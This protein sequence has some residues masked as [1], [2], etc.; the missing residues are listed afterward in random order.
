MK[1]LP[2][3][4]VILLFA[5]TWLFSNNTAH[6]QINRLP[7]I[8]EEE[9]EEQLFPIDIVTS[10]SFEMVLYPT[11]ETFD[12]AATNKVKHT[13]KNALLL[14]S[15]ITTEFVSLEVIE[16]LVQRVEFK[17]NYGLEE[18]IV[19][20]GPDKKN[21]TSHVQASL[22]E[23]KVT[24]Y[25]D[26]QERGFSPPPSQFATDNLI[27]RTFSQPSTKS[28]FIEFITLTRDPFL[29]EVEDIDINLVEG[30][31]EE[32][33][34]DGAIP[35]SNID[36]VLIV[37]SSFILIGIFF[38]FVTHHQKDGYEDIRQKDSFNEKRMLATTTN[39]NNNRVDETNNKDDSND[40]EEDQISLGRM[41]PVEGNIIEAGSLESSIDSQSQIVLSV[42]DE[43]PAISFASSSSS[44]SNSSSSHSSSSSSSDSTY[45]ASPEEN[46]GTSREAS[47]C[48]PKGDSTIDSYS[49][50]TEEHYYDTT[51]FTKTTSELASKLLSLSGTDTYNTRRKNNMVHSSS[52]SAPTILEQTIRQSK[53]ESKMDEKSIKSARS[54]ASSESLELNNKRSTIIPISFRRFQ[55]DQVV[56]NGS[57]MLETT[58]EFHNS[59]LE[60]KIKALEDIEEGSIDDV[61]QI[62]VQRNEAAAALE[63]NE[64][65]TSTWSTS[66]SEWMKSIRVVSSASETQSSV[67]HSSIEPKSS[68][69]RENNS[70]DLSLEDSLATSLVEF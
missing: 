3:Y 29:I 64:T 37:A 11:P 58:E 40:A 39:D 18:N 54:A 46:L 28:S 59:W 48:E 57:I 68:H 5:I 53:N 55:K 9:E 10:S 22:I 12:T 24:M 16:I 14:S 15:S 26:L 61:F 1:L 6:A 70:I 52:A 63:E 56:L 34:V 47:T 50:G 51:V 45:T 65:I 7:S 20:A 38:I 25:F 27:V 49:I 36:I 13:I 60:S 8:E 31:N 66:V 44:E 62:D 21:F 19:T 23:F 2:H 67:E 41:M 4:I 42:A 35:L 33:M 30:L 69:A 17:E 32:T 43:S